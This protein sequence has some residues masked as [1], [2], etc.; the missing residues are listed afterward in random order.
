[1]EENY[2]AWLWEK[3]AGT[4]V[5]NLKKHRFDAH[6]APDAKRAAAL[7]IDLVSQY[8]TFG[9]GGSD[10]VRAMGIPAKLEEMGKTIYDHWDP[11]F[12]PE[13]VHETRLK[14]GRADC[15]QR[16]LP[17]PLQP[18]RPS[19]VDQT[20]YRGARSCCG[21]RRGRGPQPRHFCDRLFFGPG[22]FRRW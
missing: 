2:Q 10:T 6:F 19:L 20:H 9:F 5:K 1:M 22:C 15:S 18:R 12:T 14:Q 17:R 11:S 7:I 8:E 4:C 13:Q 21:G 3:Q 16:G